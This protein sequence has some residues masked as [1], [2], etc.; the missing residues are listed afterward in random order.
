MTFDLVSPLPLA[1]CIRRLR[2]AA[3]TGFAISGKKPVLGYVGDTS[4]RLRRRTYYRHTAQCWLSGQFVEEGGQTRL[5][6]TT[7]MHPLMRTLL[8]YWVGAVVLGGGYV[9]LRSA[10]LFFTAH[11]PLPEYLWL[12]LAV[13]PVLLGF[14]AV[15]LAF[16]DQNFGSDPRFLLEFVARTIDGKEVY[17]PP[18]R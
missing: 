17:L 16:G 5:H 15:L 9:F 18:P 10:R 11:G 7:G 13:P 6:C 4:I 3:D 1:E 2:A 8:E 12:G 14:G